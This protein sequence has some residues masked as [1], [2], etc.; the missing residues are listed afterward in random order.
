MFE[1]AISNLPKTERTC[2]LKYELY[3]CEGHNNVTRLNRESDAN[4]L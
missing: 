4:I 3:D 1:E 2:L